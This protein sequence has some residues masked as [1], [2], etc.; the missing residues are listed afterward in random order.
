MSITASIAVTNESTVLSNDEVMH[1]LPALQ[2]QANY[3]FAPHW[4][5]G[6]RLHFTDAKTIPQGMW[7]IAVV[8]DTDQ[9]GALGYH[10]LDDD[11]APDAFIFAATDKQY[12]LSWSVTFSHEL[13]EMLADAFI[14]S[15]WQTS[16]NEWYATEVCDPVEADELGY[17]IEVG[18]NPPVLVSDFVLPRWF[19]PG[20]PKMYDYKNHCTMPLQILKGG[21]ASVF[22]SGQGWTQRQNFDGYVRE[23]VHPVGV[24]WRRPRPSQEIRW[25]YAKRNV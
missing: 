8:D 10:D 21:Y 9:Q 23:S 1:A 4:H 7:H 24:D 13:L 11:L 5:T 3:H 12:G 22:V 16:S 17:E 6:A 14:S 15:G 19:I 18:G 20:A 25:E 2:H